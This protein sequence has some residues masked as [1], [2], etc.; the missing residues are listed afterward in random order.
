MSALQEVQ[1]TFSEPVT[2]VGAADLLLGQAPAQ[3]VSG[4]GAGPYRFHFSPQPEGTVSVAWAAG[5]QI[6]DLSGNAFSG[7]SWEVQVD[8]DFSDVVINEIMYHPA[9][10]DDREEYIE[11][12]NRDTRPVNLKGWRLARGV[13]VSGRSSP[14][15]LVV[16]A[17][18]VVFAEKYPEAKPAIGGW[19]G[20]LSNSSEALVLEDAGGREADR[21]AYADE[22]DWALRVR[23]PDDR[24]FHG[25]RWEAL[26]D[27][28]G[29]SL[30]LITPNEAGGPRARSKT[31]RP[32]NRTRCGW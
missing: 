3:S 2:G 17:D 13:R 8:P 27:G 16:A 23:G 12:L 24:G 1:V 9:S 29:R 20:R 26:H 11:L 6:R 25:W 7:G 10:E 31:A 5:H 19:S 32:A 30:E 14:D 28:E 18:P 22:G 15:A 21:V 4:E